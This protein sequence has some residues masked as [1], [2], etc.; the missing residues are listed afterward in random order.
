MCY[1]LKKNEIPT[2]TYNQSMGVILEELG[3]QV[4]SNLDDHKDKVAEVANK[5]DFIVK[6]MVGNENPM[7]QTI[8]EYIKTYKSKYGTIQEQILN[9]NDVDEQDDEDQEQDDDQ[10]SYAEFVKKIEKKIGMTLN[11][12]FAMLEKYK[13]K[14]EG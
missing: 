2:E 8:N 14:D 9:G 1:E 11:E 5:I 12:L 4:I 13:A 6:E 3:C 10:G 7:Q